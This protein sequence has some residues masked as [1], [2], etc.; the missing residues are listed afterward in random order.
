V[1]EWVFFVTLV[2]RRKPIDRAMRKILLLL[3]CLLSLPLFAQELPFVSPDF[4]SIKKEISDKSSSCYYPKLFKRYQSMDTTLTAEEY[5]HLY[6]GYVFQKAYEPYEIPKE[7]QEI[8]NLLERE[9]LTDKEYDK[10]IK[11]TSKSLAKFPFN[12][13]QL[14]NQSFAY[15]MKGEEAT[16]IKLRKQLLDIR[17]AIKTSGDGMKRESAYHVISVGNE[18]EFL[19]SYQLVALSQ[20]FVN[21][22]DYIKLAKNQYEIEGIYFNVEQPYK[23]M[24]VQNKK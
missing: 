2:P 22:C 10:I 13:D 9:T 6:Y 17:N 7:N 12:L 16:S 19:R 18:Y 14:I 5:R 21:M 11:L 20:E 23:R 1:I 4:P 15:H 24:I 3:V 8:S